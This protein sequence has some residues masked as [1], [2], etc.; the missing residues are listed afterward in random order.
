MGTPRYMVPEQA[1][2]QKVDVRADIFSLG[3]M[4]YEMLAGRP[5]FAGETPD[6]IIAS[7]LRDEPPPLAQYAPEA[8][9][10]I[11]KFYIDRIR[12]NVLQSIP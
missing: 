7:I 1:R 3:V 11:D 10:E 12:G 2:G 5:P 4:L 8:P 6:E 9:P